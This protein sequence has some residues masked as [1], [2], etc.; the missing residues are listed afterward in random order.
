MRNSL[1][2][3]DRELICDRKKFYRIGSRLRLRFKHLPL[4]A[5]LHTSSNLTLD[6]MYLGTLLPTKTRSPGTNAC[7]N[8]RDKTRVHM[9]AKIFP[10][11]KV[12][13]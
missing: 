7:G 5:A 1:A 3:Y 8:H 10:R 2:Y 12:K 4:M 6:T 9:P 11:L 13:C